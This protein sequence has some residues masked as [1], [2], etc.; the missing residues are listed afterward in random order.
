M[1]FDKDVEKKYRQA[2]EDAFATIMD[3]GNAR[4][5]Q[6]MKMILD[7]E[8]LVSV[9]PLSQVNASG[10]TGVIDA[11]QLNDRI[12]SERLSLKDAFGE[13]AI[14]LAEETI[15]GGGQRGCQGTFVHESQHAFDFA[16]T[17]ESFSNADINPLSV[18]NPSLYDLEWEAHLAAGEYA[19]Q[20]GKDDY[21]EEG[22]ALMILGRNDSGCFLD[23]NGIKQR[24]KESY[25]LDL[26][27]NLG[28]LA[29]DMLGLRQR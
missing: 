24:L 9:Y 18:F 5:R 20:I 11:G 7:S 1:K 26:S 3:K 13:L 19:M 8:M 28:S 10:I 25:G 4:H 14:T 23:H 22:V 17:I 15:A 21:L 29:S 2:L 27:G 16:Q 6:T 12:E